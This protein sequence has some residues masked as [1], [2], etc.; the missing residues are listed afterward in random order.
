L[1]VEG[2]LPTL[3]V[4]ARP[5]PELNP[6]AS[7]LLAEAPLLRMRFWSGCHFWEPPC[8]VLA[9]PPVFRVLLV[10]RVLLALVLREELTVVLRLLLTFTST[11]PCP[12]LQLLARTAP[13]AMPTPKVTSGAIGL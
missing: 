6:R 10:L 4:D 12:Q 7:R 8:L 2:R 5:P 1:P 9:D 13:H 11:S 3:P